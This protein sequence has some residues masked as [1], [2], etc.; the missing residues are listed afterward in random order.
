V[1]FSQAYAPV[2]WALWRSNNYVPEDLIMTTEYCGSRQDTF[3]INFSQSASPVIT[4]YYQLLRLG[5][6]LPFNKGKYMILNRSGFEGYEK[7]LSSFMDIAA[8]LVRALEAM[9]RGN[10][11]KVVGHGKNGNLPVVSWR[12]KNEKIYDGEWIKPK[13]GL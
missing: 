10:L 6:S 11:F 7:M 13:V 9:D 12:S 3:N 4:Q 1:P 5:M 8:T 2:G